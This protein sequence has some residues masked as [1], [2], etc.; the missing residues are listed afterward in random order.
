MADNVKYRMS[1]LSYKKNYDQSDLQSGS[2]D[3]SLCKRMR[4]EYWSHLT[5]L[6]F[7]RYA[8]SGIS[9]YKT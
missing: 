9:S 7:L 3:G 4:L 1:Y 8:N 2:E 5:M 6:V